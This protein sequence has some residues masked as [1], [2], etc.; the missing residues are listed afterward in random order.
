MEANERAMSVTK[1]LPDEPRVFAA[2]DQVERGQSEVSALVNDLE[3]RLGGVLVHH[4][5]STESVGELVDAP[6]QSALTNRLYS[7]SAREETVVEQLRG[8][9]D[10]L[11]V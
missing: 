6:N 2:L 4:P 8:M 1:S 3:D 11:E 7:L 9:L 5:V 10:R